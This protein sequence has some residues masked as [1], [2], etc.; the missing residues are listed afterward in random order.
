MCCITL[1]G[2][3]SLELQILSRKLIIV[4]DQEKELP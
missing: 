3:G 1:A 2:K 4:D